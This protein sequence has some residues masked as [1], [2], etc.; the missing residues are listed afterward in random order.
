M[1]QVGGWEIAMSTFEGWWRT[2]GGGRTS[3]AH[4]KVKASARGE[5]PSAALHRPRQLRPGA[6]DAQG[7]AGSA[8]HPAHS[9]RRPR[10][11]WT[12]PPGGGPGASP[13]P[14]AAR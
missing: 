7:R 1:F 12:H 4:L 5:E 9:P 11:P 6:G 14:R 8:T 10:A 3:S 13:D 2:R